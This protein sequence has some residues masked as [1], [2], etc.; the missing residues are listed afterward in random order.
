MVDRQ[1]DLKI[2]IKATAILFGQY[3]RIMIALL[4]VSSL[5]CLYFA[6]QAFGLGTYYNASLAV[7]AALFSYHQY[8]IR[9]RKPEDCF[10]AFL[11]NNWVGMTIFVGVALNY[12]TDGT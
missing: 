2:G 12:L 1:D 8:L 3:D 11:H 5:I 4:Q 6:G 10:K 9:E 7:S